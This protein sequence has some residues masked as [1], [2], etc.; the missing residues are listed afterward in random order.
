[1]KDKEN[2]NN[3]CKS[4]GSKSKGNKNKDNKNKDNKG[5]WLREKKLL[6][7]NYFYLIIINND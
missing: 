7:R 4:K 3:N 5:F 1:M 2:K 6:S